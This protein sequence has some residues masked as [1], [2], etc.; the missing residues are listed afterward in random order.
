MVNKLWFAAC[1]V[2]RVIIHQEGIETY[3]FE[4]DPPDDLLATIAQHVLLH[5]N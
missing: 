2:H 5:L 4:S 1:P 3:G